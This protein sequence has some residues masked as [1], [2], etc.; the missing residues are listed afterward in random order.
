MKIAGGAEY[1]RSASFGLS[2]NA[3]EQAKNVEPMERSSKNL[4]EGNFVQQH[5]T[6]SKY[7]DAHLTGLRISN[8]F[9]DKMQG[10]VDYYSSQRSD[11]YAELWLLGRKASRAVGDA[12]ENEV[13]SSEAKRMEKEREE[14]EETAAERNGTDSEENAISEI[15]TASETSSEK[16][17]DEKSTP[18]EAADAAK[19][20]VRDQAK[21]VAI[22]PGAPQGARISVAPGGEEANSGGAGAGSSLDAF[23]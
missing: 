23:V 13:A 14:S 2:P 18:Q 1:G 6:R 20:N 4:M 11:N 7:I 9:Q 17:G 12:V 19:E 22:E 15:N 21:A 5:Y 10:I 16:Q 3:S 8:E